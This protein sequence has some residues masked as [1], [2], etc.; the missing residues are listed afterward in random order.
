EEV[1]D[2]E[3]PV[4]VPRVFQIE[5]GWESSWTDICSRGGKE[6]AFFNV[7]KESSLEQV[8]VFVRVNRC[9]EY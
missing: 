8:P 7:E 4:L 3:S 5:Y 1:M 9:A 6:E 2:M